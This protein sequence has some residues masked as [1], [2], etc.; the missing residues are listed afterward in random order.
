[1]MKKILLG[2]AALILGLVSCGKD[3]PQV[4]T[5]FKCDDVKEYYFGDVKAYT[6]VVATYTLKE[7]PTDTIWSEHNDLRIKR[8]LDCK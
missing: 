4:E 2:L 7:R 1:M 6:I 8:Y 3:E 5:C